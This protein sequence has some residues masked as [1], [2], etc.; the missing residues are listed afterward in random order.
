MGN[1]EQE[2]AISQANNTYELG[3]FIA[4]N[5]KAREQFGRFAWSYAKDNKA[6]VVGRFATG[7]FLGQFSYG[8]TSPMAMSGD[9]LYQ[10]KVLDDFARSLVLGE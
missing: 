10:A 4:T 2:R 6:H 3:K 8:T 5:D 9:V 1:F 7:I